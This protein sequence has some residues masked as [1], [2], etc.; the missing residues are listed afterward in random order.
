MQKTCL[1]RSSDRF[2]QEEGGDKMLIIDKI[3]TDPNDELYDLQAKYNVRINRSQ[4]SNTVYIF[5]TQSGFRIRIGHPIAK[6]QEHIRN[7]SKNIISNDVS[8]KFVE[9]Q[10]TKYLSKF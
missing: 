7:F 8:K 4:S 6:N 10:I 3:I 5:R 1:E 9:E 2:L